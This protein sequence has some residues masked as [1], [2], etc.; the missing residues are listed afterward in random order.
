M[1]IRVAVAPETGKPKAVMAVELE[2]S[3]ASDVLVEIKAT[4]LCHTDEF[5]RSRDDPEGLFTTI[6]GHEGAD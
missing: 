6:L 5:N 1:R 4:G 3:S 2:S